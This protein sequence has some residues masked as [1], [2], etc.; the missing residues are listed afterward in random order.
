MKEKD[1]DSG[2]ITTMW[3][4]K[5]QEDKDMAQRGSKGEDENSVLVGDI[6]PKLSAGSTSGDG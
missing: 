5:E 4:L 6:K 1:P 3:S 2:Q